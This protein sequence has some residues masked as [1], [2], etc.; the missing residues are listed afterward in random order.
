MQTMQTYW[1]SVEP[2]AL[3]VFCK[4]F[5]INL[6]QNELLA[7]ICELWQNQEWQ[8][9][10]CVASKFKLAKQ[11][12]EQL[13]VIAFLVKKDE[14]ELIKILIKNNTELATNAVRQ[15]CTNKHCKI[16]GKIIKSAGLKPDD[17]PALSELFIK[18]ALRYFMF[19]DNI[20]LYQLVELI[21]DIPEA[22]SFVV[23]EL[24]IQGKKHKGGWQIC[25]A[26][27]LLNIHPELPI[28]EQVKNALSIF[29]P[30][31]HKGPSQN[32][33]CLQPEYDLCYP[34][35][36][37]S[38]FFI[39]TCEQLSMIDFNRNIAGIDCEWR[40]CLF[41]FQKTKVSLFQIAFEDGVFLIDMIKLNKEPLLDEILMK[42]LQGEILKVGVSFAGDKG[43]LNKSYPHMKAFKKPL[44]NYIELINACTEI[45]GCNPG[46]LAGSCEL[47]LNQTLCKYEQRS[48]WEIRPLRES[49]IHY[50]ALDSY[51]Q[52]MIIKVLCE[53]HNCQPEE[54]IG[55]SKKRGS[56]GPSSCKHCD[57]KSHKDKNCPRGPRCKICYMTGHKADKCQ[58]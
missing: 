13:S 50:S 6:N 8:K 1:K 54:L 5:N 15:M 28:N 37:N 46:G 31:I 2:K 9:A 18:N 42:F 27:A 24:K 21:S 4:I 22:L 32:F 36:R 39:D 29:T 48:N 57:S 19:C 58:N 44:K 52:L 11:L 38:I 35:P 33:S 51:V 10:I 41:K 14:I 17:F 56:S 43:M 34:L 3:E 23:E 30:R 25:M 12:E 16:A 7:Y 47:I 45:T 26:H 53:N 49:Q 55:K 40:P 20:C